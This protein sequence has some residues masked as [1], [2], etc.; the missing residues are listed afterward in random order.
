MKFPINLSLFE[1]FRLHLS[2]FNRDPI[3]FK[4]PEDEEWK[5]LEYV[6]I[7]V[8][9]IG[10]KYYRRYHKIPMMVIDSVD[11]VAKSDQRCLKF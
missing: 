1:M 9:D 4:L 7:V 11:A 2:I 5:Q 10:S 3:I 8:W 6:M